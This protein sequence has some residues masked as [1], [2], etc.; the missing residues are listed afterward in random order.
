VVTINGRVAAPDTIIRNGDRLES[1][2]HKHEPPVTSTPV[3][4]IR[5]EPND[6]IVI[7]KPGSIP[8]HGCGRYFRNSL[9]EILKND[10]GFEKVHPVNRLDR[11]TSGLMILPLNATRANTVAKEFASGT[12]KKE[13]VARV[14]GE[15]PEEE[16]TCDQPLLTVDRQI[17]LNIVHPEGKPAKT[18]F[19]R[20][21]Y[22]SNTDTSV[23]R[24]RPQTGRSHQIRVHL[25]YLGYPIANDNIYSDPNVWGERVGMGGLDLTPSE[26][27]AAPVVPAHLSFSNSD[28]PESPLS[29]AARQDGNG[30]L[31]SDR[32]EHS[33][34][35][36]L[37]PQPGSSTNGG[38]PHLEVAEPQRKL[39]PRETGHDI[40]MASPVPLSAEMVKVITRLRNMK[41]E[42]E[43]WS[44]WR[45]VVFRGKAA[46]APHGVF[47]PNPP[48]P[49]ERKRGVAA[50]SSKK[51]AAEE[52]HTCA[53]ENQKP[54]PV[55]LT[56]AEALEKLKDFH[57]ASPSLEAAPDTEVASVSG[58][59]V[60]ADSIAPDVDESTPAKDSTTK[61]ALYCHECYLPL[62]PDPKPERLYIFL[63]ALRYTTESLG[64]FETEM[65]DWAAEGWVWER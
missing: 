63:H 59:A 54:A 47:T 1:I 4:I 6:Y 18:I 34:A 64:S 32:T 56:Q 5:H 44:R 52:V 28:N 38:R 60:T 40:G 14:R 43:D 53:T 58:S 30:T 12:V 65:P 13:Y 50:K 36:N 45:D 57:L 17:G 46:L 2:V 7:D 11:L 20:M 3:K 62:H 35:I 51:R 27:R 21:H 41:D 39:L 48:P 9:I 25:Q 23:V 33:G 15:F 8:I 10:F 16:I 24:C 22:D 26:Q 31:H 42:D 49:N 55:Q 37:A 61:T 29:Q 19:K